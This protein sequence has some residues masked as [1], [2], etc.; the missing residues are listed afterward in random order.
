MVLSLSRR[1][2]VVPWGVRRLVSIAYEEFSPNRKREEVPPVLAIHGALGDRKNWRGLMKG[3]SNNTGM[4]SICV[5]M[6]NHGDSGQSK[7]FNQELIVEDM[8]ELIKRLGYERVNLMGHSFGGKIVMQLALRNDELVNSIVV[9]DM[10]PTKGELSNIV[11]WSINEMEAI[12]D[13]GVFKTFGELKKTIDG[14]VLNNSQLRNFILLSTTTTKKNE[15]TNFRPNIKAIKE[16][17]DSVWD[18]PDAENFAYKFTKPALFVYGEKSEFNI[19][20]YSETIRKFFPNSELQALNTGHFV[21][22]DDPKG[23]MDTVCK[24]YEKI[25][26]Q[27]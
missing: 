8:K 9:V 22:A 12:D 5:D 17:L 10:A 14:R 13:L 6:R 19:G 15:G 3:L 11:R 1:V 2:K 23:Y 27:Y 18:F 16:N 26:K 21:M 7:E 4:T 25:H 24:F 20:K